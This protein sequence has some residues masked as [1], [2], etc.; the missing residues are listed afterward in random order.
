MSERV[1]IALRKLPQRPDWR[2][3]ILVCVLFQFRSLAVRGVFI[4]CMDLF[5]V[6]MVY[7]LDA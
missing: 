5:P 4:I 6:I 2:S 3:R 1:V 7:D